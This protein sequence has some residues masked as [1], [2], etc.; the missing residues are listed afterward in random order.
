M[1]G[2]C[3]FDLGAT[4][5]DRAV[6]A[7]VLSI[8]GPEIRDRLGVPLFERRG[9]VAP[10]LNDRFL[11][12]VAR[13]TCLG[14]LALALRR[15]VRGV[16]HQAKNRRDNPYIHH[17]RSHL[18]SFGSTFETDGWVAG[19]DSEA[20]RST[21]PISTRVAMDNLPFR[22]ANTHSLTAKQ[23]MVDVRTRLPAPFSKK[24]RDF[25]RAIKRDAIPVSPPL[26]YHRRP[27]YRTGRPNALG[28]NCP[29]WRS[30]ATRVES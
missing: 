16:P 10:G 1:R 3:L 15:A 24:S 8:F 14:F 27:I 21:Q 25:H 22:L 19:S 13:R 9:E 4:S 30:G 17:P 12:I 20:H 6:F 26:Q 7:F 28:G 18:P 11:I 23:P 29:H 5:Q 2:E